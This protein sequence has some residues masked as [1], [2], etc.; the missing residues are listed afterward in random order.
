MRNLQ[1]S[2]V[3]LILTLWVSMLPLGCQ[4]MKK[5]TG[6]Q[7]AHFSADP[8]RV[9]E[10]AK[11]ALADLQLEVVSATASK[12]DGRIEG[13][14]AQGKPITIQVEREAEGVSKASVKV[15]TLGDDSIG[16]AIIQK[17]DEH[18]KP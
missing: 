10:A 13:K 15:G 14:T 7:Y 5:A 8:D 17:T 12:L 16:D 9:V 3:M 6:T 2:S 1:R 4:T 18:L 11:A